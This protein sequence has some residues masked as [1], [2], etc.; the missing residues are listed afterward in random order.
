MQA[1][2]FLSFWIWNWLLAPDSSQRSLIERL[3]ET[4]KHKLQKWF[5]IT[6]LLNLG[7]FIVSAL[8]EYSINKGNILCLLN[9]GSLPILSIGVLATNL[10]YLNENVPDIN[11]KGTQDGIDGL[12]GKILV[13]SILIII[14]SAALYFAQSNFVSS[15][16]ASQLRYSL[17]ASAALFVYAISCG[18]K[19]FLLQNETMKDY[20]A[21]MDAQRAALIN[22]ANNGYQ[23]V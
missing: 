10:V 19:M 15:F 22:N 5:Y 3:T 18:R 21:E 12:K 17:I 13:V 6:V 16:D 9:N 2:R 23:T 11:D 1:V 8:F 14:I 20:K 4:N 7:P